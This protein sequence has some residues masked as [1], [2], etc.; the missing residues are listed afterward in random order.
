MNTNY[1]DLKFHVI[2]KDVKTILG[3]SDI[4]RLDLIKLD[5]EVHSIN[6]AL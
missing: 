4:L 3:L 1:G 2:N 5:G 6:N